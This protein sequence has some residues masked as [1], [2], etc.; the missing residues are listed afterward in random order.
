MRSGLASPRIIV[1]LVE[2]SG[3]VFTLEINVVDI[4]FLPT[5]EIS[6]SH[7]Y[8]APLNSRILSPASI[9][10]TFFICRAIEP[11]SDIAWPAV[12]ISVT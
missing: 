2:G 8:P 10:N 3:I 6:T 9:L 12:S 4:L 5:L 11:L 7:S 1:I